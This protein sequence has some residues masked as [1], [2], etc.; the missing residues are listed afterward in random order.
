MFGFYGY[1]FFFGGIFRT[2]EDE[3]F[4]KDFEKKERYTGG[5]VIG[6]MFMILIGIMQLTAIGPNIKALTEG[7]I[8]GK[9]AYDTIDHIPKV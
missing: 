3:W 5:D 6:V 9:L 7:K 1:A 8:G 4:F 2:S